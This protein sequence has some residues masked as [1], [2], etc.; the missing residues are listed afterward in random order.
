[1]GESE[2]RLLLDGVVGKGSLD[3][4]AIFFNSNLSGL[5]FCSLLRL[6]VNILFKAL[7]YLSKLSLKYFGVISELTLDHTLL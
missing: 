1:M 3:H 4:F 6:L 7:D 5:I 2:S